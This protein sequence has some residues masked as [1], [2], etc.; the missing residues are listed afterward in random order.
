MDLNLILMLKRF[1]KKYVTNVGRILQRKAICS[2]QSSVC[3]HFVGVFTL[4]KI[5]NKATMHPNN[6]KC[7]F[8]KAILI[9]TLALSS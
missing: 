3:F 4:R 5:N 2:K 6:P 8:Y 1:S 7:T 9:A